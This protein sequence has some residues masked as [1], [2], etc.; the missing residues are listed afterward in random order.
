MPIMLIIRGV[1]T[2]LRCTD[3]ALGLE[4]K[5]KIRLSERL[6]RYAGAVGKKL[7]HHEE[8]SDT[9]NDGSLPDKTCE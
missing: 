6:Q 1:K 9:E 4:P 5:R 2:G 8:H 7:T 3:K